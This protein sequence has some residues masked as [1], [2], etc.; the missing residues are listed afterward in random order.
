[1]AQASGLPSV[2][3]GYPVVFVDWVDSCEPIPNAEISAY[4]LPQ[5]QRIFQVGFLVQDD[6]DH[7]CVAGGLKPETETYDYVIAI[8]RCSIVAI[9]YLTINEETEVD[10]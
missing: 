7:V 5:P 8:P 6:E 2:R 4:D 1:M 3:E 10:E 9:R